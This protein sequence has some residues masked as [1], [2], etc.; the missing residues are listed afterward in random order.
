MHWTLHLSG[1]FAEAVAAGEEVLASSGRHPWA[2]A[3]LAVILADWGKPAAAEALYVELMARAGRGYVQP[4][5]LAIVAAAAGRQDEALRYARESVEIRDAS[6]IWFS[7]YLPYTARL[8]ADPR[9]QEILLKFGT[10]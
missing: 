4:S 8:R 10:G 3:T 1:R 5:Q 6:V 2:M 7:K 9:F